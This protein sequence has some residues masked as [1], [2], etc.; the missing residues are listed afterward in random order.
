MLYVVRDG[1]RDVI[2]F[3][4]RAGAEAA[5][6]SIAE[7]WRAARRRAPG[8]DVQVLDGGVLH[9]N[10]QVAFVPPDDGAA[11][12]CAPHDAAEASLDQLLAGCGVGSS[13]T[14]AHTMTQQDADG[15]VFL[16]TR[17]DRTTLDQTTPKH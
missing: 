9:H 16:C 11:A 8:Y 12:P 4:S 6:R 5:R 2:A 7:G 17:F 15:L 14:F 1:R 10:V 3:R 13:L